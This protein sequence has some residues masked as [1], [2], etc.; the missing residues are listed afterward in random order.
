MSPHHDAGA[1]GGDLEAALA[2]A[3]HLLPAQGPISVFVHHNTLHAFEHLPFH[4][5]LLECERLLGARPYL[6]E[7]AY[8]DLLKVGRIT[9]T[10]VEE[11]YARIHGR[12]LVDESETI[13]GVAPRGVIRRA[14]LFHGVRAP[15]G[16]EV[17]FLLHDAG[18]LDRFRPG[19]SGAGA[20]FLLKGASGP[21]EVLTALFD[22]ATSLTKG[23]HAPASAAG[24]YARHRD[25]LLDLAGVDTDTWIHPA[26]IRWSAAFLDGGTAYWPMPLREQGFY[27]AVRALEAQPGV[28]RPR[29]TAGA[30]DMLRDLER[31][32]ADAGTACREALAGLGVGPERYETY[33]TA[34]LAA[35]RGFAGMF[36]KLEA[37][38]DPSAPARP[39]LLDFAAIRLVYELSATRFAAAQ[40]G[41]AGR[42]PGSL[43]DARSSPARVPPAGDARTAAY[44][45]FQLLQLLGIRPARARAI[46]REGAEALLAEVSAFGD[47]ERRRVWHDAYEMRYAREVAG[48]IAAHPPCPTFEPRFQVMTCIDDREESFR[49]HIEEVDPRVETIGAAGFFGLPVD[50]R[51]I[52]DAHATA[53]CPVVVDPDREIHE[54]PHPEDLALLDVRKKR[55]RLA[56]VLSREIG[57]S[58]RMFMRGAIL[59]ALVGW[60]AVVPM[61][62][63][64]LFPRW[65]ALVSRAAADRA[66]P[67]P[68]TRLAV[69]P[70][71]H[72]HDERMLLGMPHEERADRVAGFLQSIGLTRAFSPLVLL[73][74]HGSTSHNNPLLSAYDCGACGGRH[75][76]PNARLFARFANDPGLRRELAARGVT[77]PDG[78]WFV[79]GE[80]DTCTDAIF[81][82]DDEEIPASHRALFDD[83]V[84]VLDEARAR[85]AHERCRRFDFAPRDMSPA[86]ALA[87]AERRAFAYDEPRPEYGHA[88]N[89]FAVVGRRTRTRG[90][91]LD[92][93]AFLVSYDPEAD[94]AGDVL[95]RVLGAVGPVCA[96]INLEYYF[97]TIDNEIHGCGT[98]LP[99]NITAGVGVMNGAGS[100]LRTGLARQ[101]IELHEPMRLLVIVEQK[102]GTLLSA[103][104]RLPAVKALVTREWIRVAALDPD[105]GEIAFLSP[106]GTFSAPTRAPSAPLVEVDLSAE[107]YAG[108]SEHLRPARARAALRGLV[109]QG[110]EAT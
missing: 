93:R 89:A 7:D 82:W 26:L 72:H 22:V 49:R 28:L 30:G 71:P 57:T 52:D 17:A 21:R 74:G 108:R 45:L 55:R 44:V 101:M 47:R 36:H 8:R 15:A 67:K 39:T 61:A 106:D 53:R 33:L 102:Q 107:H 24:P 12:R 68:R 103:L 54:H 96:G 23:R 109:P 56:A 4:E 66:V 70:A 27:R 16:D 29:W 38:T 97:S 40:A 46:D 91:F 42:S 94:E 2:H 98:K 58:S 11:A 95:V 76:G 43:L 90:L 65:T 78:T 51:G 48:A 80:H 5:A 20:A 85:G 63:R 25:A 34:T 86:G 32:D 13:G 6:E 50:Y 60:L 88:T 14:L 62:A 81:F 83:A 75:G 19:V 87:E 1:A 18:G 64:V 77:I 31:R 100:D 79:G 35:L 10:D 41:L 105:R 84:R 3:A 99:H 59:N 110:E 69:E 73:L 37:D 92:R 104:D 9:A